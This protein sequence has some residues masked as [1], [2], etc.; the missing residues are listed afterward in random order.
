M[1]QA[2]ITRLLTATPQNDA[3][4]NPGYAMDYGIESPAPEWLSVDAFAALRMASHP[5]H[6]AVM[7][8][9]LAA[10]A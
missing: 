7:D 1:F 6:V 3:N 5:A 10:G 9:A 8:A 4:G 2:F